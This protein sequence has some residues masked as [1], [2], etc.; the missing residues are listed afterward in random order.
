MKRMIHGLLIALLLLAVT[1]C[2][3]RAAT[4]E[5]GSR[6]GDVLC[7]K[8]RLYE[9]GYFSTDKFSDEY[10]GTTAERVRQL[11]KMNGLKQTGSVSEALWTLIFS[12]S[13]IDAKGRARVMP[14]PAPS[15][16]PAPDRR[17]PIDVPGAPDRDEKGFLTQ[18]TEFAVRDMENG[19]WAYLSDTLQ[20]VVRRQRDT[21]E[22]LV[23]FECDIRTGEG[24]RMRALLTADGKWR[25]P[26]DIARGEQAVLAFSDDFHAY[27]RYNKYVM[28]I[29]IRNGEIVS[30][31]TKR[32]TQ[33]GFPKLE[34]MAYLA[35]GSL[36]CY[37]AQD[38]TAEEYLAMG[39]T[40]VLAFGPI[41]VTNGQLGEKMRATEKEAEKLDYYH[42]REPRMALGMVEPGHYIVLCVTGR[43][44]I[45]KS[46]VPG[47]NELN[48]SRGVYLDWLAL[49]MLELGATEALNLDGG[50]STSLCFL[51]ESL[52][53]SYGASRKTTHL[54][55]FGASGL[56]LQE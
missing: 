49:K 55:G 9:L 22:R 52:N 42:Y 45:R 7:L 31:K 16:T 14:T 29:V 15:P 43:T 23:W 10:N 24:E 19:F 12:D 40:D 2:A 4:L 46:M 33:S 27:R 11:Q 34:N 50:Y 39:A 28:G 51:G 54:M 35:D 48:V 8:Q 53:I 56:A 37:N 3:A 13:C 1:G 17:L 41:L 5:R 20:V 21:K 6:G 38:H 44:N 32:P 30:A 18:D 47:I 36:K 26:R 25:L